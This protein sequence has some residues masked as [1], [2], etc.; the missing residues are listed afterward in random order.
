MPDASRWTKAR[1]FLS[2][3][4]I[5]WIV[6]RSRPDVV[7]STGAA[8]G[9]FGLVFGK[10]IRART[11]WVDSLANAETLSLS[12]AKVG[13]FADMWLTQWPHLE[14]PEGPRY[15]GSVL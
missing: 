10:L 6:L 4:K 14:R 7:V 15:L 9:F 1:L 11:I 3:A 2:A 13:R 5:G 8:P 12:G